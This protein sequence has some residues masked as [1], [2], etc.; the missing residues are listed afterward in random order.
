MT[1][2]LAKASG[3]VLAAV[4]S[5]SASFVGASCTLGRPA[6]SVRTAIDN[7]NLDKYRD[8]FS[9]AC[10]GPIE[11][12]VKVGPYDRAFAPIVNESYSAQLEACDNLNHVAGIDSR[13]S[14]QRAVRGREAHVQFQ[15]GQSR[16]NKLNS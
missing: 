6:S 15:R 1:H 11:H 13:T 10:S 16:S 14:I 12:N 8:Y 2:L 5:T 4:I 9:P 7:A 3:P